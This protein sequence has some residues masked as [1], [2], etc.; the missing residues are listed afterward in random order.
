MQMAAVGA[1]WFSDAV[2]ILAFRWGASV[3]QSLF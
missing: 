3:I 2:S 1:F